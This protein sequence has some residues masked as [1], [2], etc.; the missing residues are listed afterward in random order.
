MKYLIAISLSLFTTTLF[1]QDS[2]NVQKSV[3]LDKIEEVVRNNISQ[4]KLTSLMFDDAE[5]EAINRAL[6]SFKNGNT[7]LPEEAAESK[8]DNVTNRMSYVYLASIM[9][10]SEEYWAVW[11]NDEKITSESNQPGNELYLQ[12]VQKDK[13]SVL[14]T[15]SASK[16]KI[17]IGRKSEE[18][19]EKINS[20]NQVEAKFEL[21]PNQTYLLIYDNVI[22]GNVQT[23]E[24]L[25][26]KEEVKSSFT[27]APMA[28]LA[29][30]A[31]Q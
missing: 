4:V 1:A 26:Q 24:S 20:Q 6:D 18:M 19:A 28:T 11:I 27:L 23:N 7:Y 30:P 3:L 29:A 31:S 16:W 15:I 25:I 17:L 8:D 22:E 9:Y 2:G 21:K 5:N 10:L 12:E 13:I 14:W